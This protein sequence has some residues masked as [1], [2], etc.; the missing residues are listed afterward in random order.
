M[1]T[2]SPV[3][4]PR[5]RRSFTARRA[6]LAGS[7][8]ST[9]EWYDFF[10]YGTASA[11]VFGDV[12]FP[13]DDPFVS[14]LLAFASFG[15]AFVARPLG[16]LIFGYLGDKFGRKPV[17][18]ITLLMMGLSTG[19]IGL[20][21]SYDSIGLAAPI[22]LVT[23]RILQGISVGGEYG[24]AVLMAVEHADEKKKSFYGSWVQAGSPAGLILCNTVFLITI[25]ETSGSAWAWRV[26]FLVSFILVAVGLYIRT[27]IAESPEFE[28]AQEEKA[29]K[30]SPIRAVL[31]EAKLRM[32]LVSLAY[33]GAGVTV[34]IVAVFSMSFGK[35]ELS[36]STEAVLTL[37]V[38]GQIAAFIAML[39]FGKLGD[40]IPYHKVFIVGCV[41][42][43]LMAVPWMA[44][45]ETG[46]H[47]VAG[48]GYVLISIPYAAVY[49]SMAVFFAT[50]FE[51]TIGYTAL[52]AGYQFGTV[53]SSAIAPMIALNLLNATGSSWSI[54]AYMTLSCFVSAIAAGILQRQKVKARRQVA[55]ASVV[56][57]SAG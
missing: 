16:G 48:A 35:V 50:T 21:P 20:L 26:P 55:A 30:T 17:L 34:Y 9:I 7:I 29:L 22:V 56:Q 28:A 41:F 1:N 33:V 54:V 47:W 2:S 10:L 46:N 39:I 8:G 53:I 51:T 43:G 38:V 40:R 6:A 37:V 27:Q 13:T 18:V 49:G 15:V 57:G 3:R 52:S 44:G 5:P 23:L 42:M 11:L 45:L 12:F 25:Y 14:R 32:A 31:K 4:D 24:G 19:V 36:Y